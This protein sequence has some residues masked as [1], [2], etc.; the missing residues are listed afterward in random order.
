MD[1]IIASEVPVCGKQSI[2]DMMVI[3]VDFLIG[4]EIKSDY[5][6]LFRLDKQ[7]DSYN[8]CFNSVYLVCGENVAKQKIDLKQSIGIMKLTD[9]QIYKKR[10]AKNRK[11]PLKEKIVEFLWKKDV[12]CS[13]NEK[14]LPVS[15]LKK[16]LCET[17]TRDELLS[18]VVHTLRKRYE[19]RFES[20]MK[21]RGR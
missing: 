5:D 15:E 12:P 19:P 4:Y 17:A 2:I 8:G 10:K 21:A 1:V 13:Y 7:I 11:Y 18:L 16:K 20:F 14:D 6:T 9:E 3:G